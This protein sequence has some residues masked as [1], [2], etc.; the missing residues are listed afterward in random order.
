MLSNTGRTTTGRHH[1]NFLLAT[2]AI[3]AFAAPALAQ[4]KSDIHEFLDVG[5]FLRAGISVASIN[6]RFLSDANAAGIKPP[7]RW[8][9]EDAARALQF[10]RSKAAEWHID[11]TRIAATGATWPGSI[12]S[13]AGGS[14]SAR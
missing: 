7:I 4:D 5:A 6:Y 11:K 14:S 2:V 3:L 8:P 9:I 1:E 12:T 13:P 10:I